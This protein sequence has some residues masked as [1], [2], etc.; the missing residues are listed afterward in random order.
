MSTFLDKSFR[1]YSSAL[2]EETHCGF[3]GEIEFEAWI[4]TFDGVNVS[5]TIS[6]IASFVKSWV[7]DINVT[8]GIFKIVTCVSSIASCTVTNVVCNEVNFAVV[9]LFEIWKTGHVPEC[10]L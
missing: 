5:F 2:E 6:S 3:R 1:I 4:E 9:S 7:C 8:F 10:E